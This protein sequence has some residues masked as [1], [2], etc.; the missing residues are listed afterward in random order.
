LHLLDDATSMASAFDEETSSC[1]E[2]EVL[3]VRPQAASGM[4]K[5]FV[6]GGAILLVLGFAGGY[7]AAKGVGSATER[8]NEADMQNVVQLSKKA[9]KKHKECTGVTGALGAPDGK[10]CTSGEGAPLSCS[11]NTVGENTCVW[12]DSQGMNYRCS[13][14]NQCQSG[15]TCQTGGRNSCEPNDNTVA[16][17]GAC[18]SDKQCYSSGYLNQKCDKHICTYKSKEG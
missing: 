18:N 5:K 1:G 14:D 8:H 10:A 13:E 15:M 3:L 9:C 4:S 6:V 17:G 7:G 12:N 11:C 2:E 16:N